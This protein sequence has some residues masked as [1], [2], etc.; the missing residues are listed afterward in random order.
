MLPSRIPGVS[1]V[2]STVR[3][4]L[5]GRWPEA[6][7]V[8]L[9]PVFCYYF[10]NF[11]AACILP[12]VK[13]FGQY[14]L[15]ALLLLASLFVL[16]PLFYGVLRWFWRA[17]DGADEDI[18]SAFYY[19][20]GIRVYI[21]AIKLTLIISFKVGV[22]FF[23]CLLPFFAVQIF[24]HFLVYDTFNEALPV[25][26]INISEFKSLFNTFGTLIATIISLRYYMIPVVAIMDENL[27]ILE[28]VH[29]SVM[30]SKK[31]LSSFFSLLCSNI[32]WFALSL[33]LLPTIYTIPFL[34]GCY[35]VHSRFAMVNYNLNVEFNEKN[36]FVGYYEV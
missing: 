1:A 17:T 6:A 21:R 12:L 14:A 35:V 16:L 30:L 7:A 5:K 25:W 31:S 27:L 15:I 8:G 26:S 9:L 2:K 36:R 11:S 3:S 33:L 18:S 32:G 10:F 4:M 13:G 20:K 34:I 22:V 28:A 29:I 23:I 19:F 24:S